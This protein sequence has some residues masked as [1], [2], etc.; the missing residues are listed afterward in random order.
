M[1]N[2]SGW[3]AEG[4]SSKEC[5]LRSTKVKRSLIIMLLCASCIATKDV[6]S[7]PREL[8]QVRRVRQSLA[9]IEPVARGTRSTEST[10]RDLIFDQRRSAAVSIDEYTNAQ[11][12]VRESMQFNPIV[13]QPRSHRMSR[14]STAAR[15]LLVQRIETASH[16]A[17]PMLCRP[18]GSKADLLVNRL[19]SLGLATVE[20]EGDGN[21][22]V[23]RC[24]FPLTCE[25]A[26]FVSHA[27]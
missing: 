17:P 22:Q 21:C 9:N 4:D 8:D 27:C 14:L 10:D 13:Q 2:L 20:M 24:K 23:C 25:Y 1:T 19:E 12:S 7:P 5:D 18:G 15:G 6:V 16:G 3:Y 26:H 11:R